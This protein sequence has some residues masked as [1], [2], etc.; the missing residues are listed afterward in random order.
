MKD[1]ALTGIRKEQNCFKI[2]FLSVEME[3]NAHKTLTLRTDNSVLKMSQ[4]ITMSFS[5]EKLV[6]RIFSQSGLHRQAK[7][8]KKPGKLNWAALNILIAM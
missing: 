3:S 6:C 1:S 7:L 5:V 2:A 4:K 8:R